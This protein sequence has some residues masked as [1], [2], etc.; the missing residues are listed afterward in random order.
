[1]CWLILNYNYKTEKSLLKTNLPVENSRGVDALCTSCQA[2]V[3][4]WHQNS[5][6]TLVIFQAVAY[7]NGYRLLITVF[8]VKLM[9]KADE[10]MKQ[11]GELE[12]GITW[13][14][15]PLKGQRRRTM[16]A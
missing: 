12:E 10:F 6:Y 8:H 11:C 5:F 13:S 15:L 16:F 7:L 1:M 9:L 3:L 14:W 4:D 2:W